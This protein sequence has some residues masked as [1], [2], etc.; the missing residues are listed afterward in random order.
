[1]IGLALGCTFVLIMGV[2]IPAERRRQELLVAD[3]QRCLMLFK[4]RT[5]IEHYDSLK[6]ESP[7]D[8]ACKYDFEDA[9]DRIGSRSFYSSIR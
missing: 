8:V 4:L 7:W 5:V 2:L 3:M 1:M 9:Y 6:N